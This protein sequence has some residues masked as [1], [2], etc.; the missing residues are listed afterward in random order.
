MLFTSDGV[1]VIQYQLDIGTQTFLHLSTQLI[2]NIQI[3]LMTNPTQL[4]VVVNA[5][6]WQVLLYNVLSRGVIARGTAVIAPDQPT[7]LIAVRQW[8]VWSTNNILYRAQLNR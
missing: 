3:V 7:H 1:S 5:A 6:P 2:A 8:L 4:L